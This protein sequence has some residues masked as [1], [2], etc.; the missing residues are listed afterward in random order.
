MPRFYRYEDR[1]YLLGPM[2][3]AP[4]KPGDLGIY[5]LYGPAQLHRVC[6][7]DAHM[8]IAHLSDR[9]LALP[10]VK[11]FERAAGPLLP[12]GR[13]CVGVSDTARTLADPP[14]MR[15]WGRDP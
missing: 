9:A 12:T 10:A 3:P 6:L 1:I 5:R 13:L 7:F 11:A 15:P 8:P 2:K 14:P 4:D